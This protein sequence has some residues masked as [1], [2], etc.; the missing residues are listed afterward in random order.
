M[1][2]EEKP[3]VSRNQETT[4]HLAGLNQL[5]I[6]QNDILD[7]QNRTNTRLT[8]QQNLILTLSLLIG[9]IVGCGSLIMNRLQKEQNADFFTYLNSEAV[10]LEIRREEGQALDRKSLLDYGWLESGLTFDIYNLKDKGVLVKQVDCNTYYRDTRY[11]YKVNRS[12]I[13]KY[14]DED[15]PLF[16]P[17]NAMKSV[18]MDYTILLPDSLAGQVKQDGI[19]RKILTVSDFTGYVTQRYGL[20]VYGEKSTGTNA[21]LYFDKI[22]RK[23]PYTWYGFEAI[24]TNLILEVIVITARESRFTNTYYLANLMEKKVFDQSR[25]TKRGKP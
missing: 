22:G 15:F 19:P 16:I 20:T 23:H 25:K 8:I 14:L 9:L 6:Q 4:A 21:G 24:N 18:G 10:A 2:P 11:T 7:N 13:N 3:D 12:S 1:N 5:L 17:P